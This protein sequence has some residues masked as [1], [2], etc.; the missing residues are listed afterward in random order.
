MAI[1][2]DEI[3]KVYGDVTA[4]DGVSLTIGGGQFH[5][6]LGPNGSGK[7]TLF[8]VMLGLTRPSGG[9]L[10][11]P[12]QR[13]GCG[14]QRPNFYPD[15]T[16][17]ENVD[18]FARMIGGVD[19]DWRETLVEEL[20]LRRA[21]GRT[22][23]EL[24]GGFA[25]KLDLALALLDK[26]DYLLLD[27]PLGALDDV[28]KT[29][30]L[31]FLDSYTDD[32]NTVLVSTHHIDDFEQ[33]VDRVTIMHRGHVVADHAVDDIDL[34]EHETIQAYYVETVL[35]RDRETERSEVSNSER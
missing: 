29:R 15:L 23:S 12:S 18:V 25:R 20:R 32:G 17:A 28:S 30:L 9:T 33:Y 24:S 21:M 10:S 14:F 11:V 7:S 4:V 6:L 13:M 22:A 5:C 16:V 34:G 31:A 19:D 8:R 35:A 1:E 26:P 27:E 2:L 3:R